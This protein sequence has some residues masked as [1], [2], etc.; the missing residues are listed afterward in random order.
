MKLE[1]TIKQLRNIKKKSRSE[2]S[3]FLRLDYDEWV[4]KNAT[5]WEN[6]LYRAKYMGSRSEDRI[7]AAIYFGIQPAFD[8]L[9]D[10]DL[11]TDLRDTALKFL[12]KMEKLGQKYFT[13]H[14]LDRLNVAQYRKDLD[15]LDILVKKLEDLPWKPKKRYME[16]E[17][18][19][20]SVRRF[21][22]SALE[23][24]KDL[25]YKPE[26]LVC[27][28]SSAVEQ[29]L[30]LSRLLKLPYALIRFSE[31]RG[32]KQA[33]HLSEDKDKIKQNCENKVV[34]V[35]E[36]YS[37]KGSTLEKVIAKVKKYKPIKVIGL[38]M[39]SGMYNKFR[40]KKIIKKTDFE[41]FN[42]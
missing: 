17:V 9:L 33:K 13:D 42:L 19:S 30:V 16:I 15:S 2:D 1:T 23:L 27:C 29:T 34:A 4:P 37:E 12:R 6:W 39:G 24:Y 38:T 21:T 11:N 22:Q 18:D 25:T 8:L 7:R 40:G 10:A 41:F 32:D 3:V 14:Q 36:D 26:F 28:A 20:K 35:I 31:K 5:P